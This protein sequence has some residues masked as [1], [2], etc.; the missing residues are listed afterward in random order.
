MTSDQ[1]Q[2]PPKELWPST[3][4]CG[5]AR[6][7][8]QPAVLV[9]GRHWGATEWPHVKV[10]GGGEGLQPGV[11]AEEGEQASGGGAEHTR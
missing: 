9:P 11:Q 5:G 6:L 3:E 2:A 1:G 10:G 8:G 4:G 7:S